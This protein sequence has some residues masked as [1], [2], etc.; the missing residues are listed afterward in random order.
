MKTLV[1]GDIRQNRIVKIL[2]ALYKVM[3]STTVIMYQYRKY[4]VSEGA[5]N[6]LFQC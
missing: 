1:L 4:I 3:Y 2:L 6:K 5:H